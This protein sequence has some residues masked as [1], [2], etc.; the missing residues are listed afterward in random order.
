MYNAT[1]NAGTEFVEPVQST[2]HKKLSSS[3]CLISTIP[4]VAKGKK[5]TFIHYQ[6][7]TLG[8][9][10]EPSQKVMLCLSVPVHWTLTLETPSHSCPHL[11]PVFCSAP[12]GH[13]LL[14]RP[15]AFHPAF[16]GSSK[17]SCQSETSKGKQTFLLLTLIEPTSTQLMWISTLRSLFWLAK[18]SLSFKPVGIHQDPRGGEWGMGEVKILAF[19]LMKCLYIG[20]HSFSMCFCSLFISPALQFYS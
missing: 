8:M 5:R 4:R 9:H 2:I 15:L 3:P 1:N 13:S 14:L 17:K 12:L 19:C 18:I 16:P 10:L 7:E 11:Y 6:M 20:D